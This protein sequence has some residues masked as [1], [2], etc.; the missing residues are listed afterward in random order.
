MIIVYYIYQ[1]FI[2]ASEIFILLI[3]IAWYLIVCSRTVRC[4]NPNK[5]MQ[6]ANGNHDN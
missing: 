6:I 4:C 5:H 2:I 3:I 1:N